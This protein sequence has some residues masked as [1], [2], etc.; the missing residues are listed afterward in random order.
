MRRAVATLTS[1]SRRR[2]P[3]ARTTSL[4]RS[5]ELQQPDVYFRLSGRKDSNMDPLEAAMG[6]VKLNK[7]NNKD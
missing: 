1:V 5:S 7:L 2:I 3:V 4:T 6:R